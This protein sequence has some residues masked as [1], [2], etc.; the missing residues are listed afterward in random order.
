MEF[1]KEEA[2]LAGIIIFQLAVILALLPGS[3]GE[4][5]GGFYKVPET[6]TP[7][8]RTPLDPNQTY[9]LRY[10]EP[11]RTV[12]IDTNSAGFRDEEWGITKDSDFRIA[13]IGDS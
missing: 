9:K 13:V 2:I 1:E 4:P 10:E 8:G 6:D 12:T 7:K 11:N 5:T 3:D